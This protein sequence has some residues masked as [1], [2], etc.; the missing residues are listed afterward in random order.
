[1]FQ[2]TLDEDEFKVIVRKWEILFLE[3][4]NHIHATE[5]D[6]IEVDEAWKDSL[7]ASKVKFSFNLEIIIWDFNG[8][9]ARS[10]ETEFH[11]N[12]PTGSMLHHHD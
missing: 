1:M 12:I 6:I 11:P 9:Y 7:T 10:D 5:F 4:V 3:V 2:Y 8:G